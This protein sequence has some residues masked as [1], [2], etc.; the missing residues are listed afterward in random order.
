MGNLIKNFFFIAAIYASLSS[1]LILTGHSSDKKSDSWDFREETIYFVMTDRFVDGEQSNNNIYGDEYRPGNLRY[2][3]GGDFKG[4]MENLNHIKDMGFSAVWITPPVKQPPGR[5]L[6]FDMTYDGTGYHGYWAWDFSAIDPH[7][8]SPGHTLEDL[9]KALHSK[10]MKLIQDVVAN[11][12]HGGYSHPSVKWH[13]QKGHIYGLGKMFDYF[14]DI[15]NWFHHSGPTIADLLD[16]NEDNS[17]T[18]DW[19]IEIYKKYQDMGVD[20]FR[21]D[22]VAWMKPEFW[23]KFTTALHKNKKDFFIFGEVWTNGDFNWI[24][25]Y[26]HLVP[27]DTMNNGMSVVDMPGS[28]MGTWGQFEK[29]FKGGDYNQVEDVL[30]NDGKYK[31]ATYLVTFLDNHDKPRFNGPGYD[32][33]SAT[34][35][36][37]IDALNFYFTARGI[38]CI[39]YGTENQMVGGNDPDNRK[40]FGT[41]GIMESK[42]NPVYGH[43]KKLN[44]IRRSNNALQKGNQTKL[45]G[46]YN[47]YAF[48]REYLNNVALVCLNKD[49]N[50]TVIS[51][52]NVPNGKYTE[53]V[54]GQTVEITNNAQNVTVPAHDLRILVQGKIKGKPWKIKTK[55]MEKKTQTTRVLEQ[56]AT[57]PRLE[58]KS[59]NRILN[60][61][62]IIVPNSDFTAEEKTLEPVENPSLEPLEDKD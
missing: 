39:Y 11:H 30:N 38:P 58:K 2:Y 36:Q 15:S 44:A 48:K 60:P 8:E 18:A 4:L 28:S 33:S 57:S 22:T 20:A 37:Y 50:S 6:N 23:T 42:N 34:T 12:G 47:Q 52:N 61:T 31:D 40:F 24:A 16:L 32:G 3:Q 43:L 1:T 10:G 7:L 14:N 56:R 21:L 53:L 25:S 9:I 59:D 62:N 29:V 55:F 13:N 49:S 54:T 45:F 17:N 27:G 41:E 19:L 46:S 5:Y 35:E 51:L 26:T